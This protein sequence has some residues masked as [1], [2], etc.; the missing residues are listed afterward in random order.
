[1]KRKIKK[2]IENPHRTEALQYTDKMYFDEIKA[3][4]GE[5]SAKY[6]Y[7]E[8]IITTTPEQVSVP[9]KK[10]DFIVKDL[11]FGHIKVYSEEIFNKLYSEVYIPK[12]TID[13][14]ITS[15]KIGAKVSREIWE[16]DEYLWI[17]GI[18]K[19][20]KSSSFA[21][22]SKLFSNPNKEEEPKEILLHKDGKDDIW[23]PTLEDVLAADWEVVEEN[24]F[25]A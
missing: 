20:E 17:K 10:G 18:E 5:H 7:G 23:Q 22:L 8:I 24:D 15:L 16:D 1:M 19:K 9:L 3:F 6:E 11:V 4:V 25:S 12:F 2:C 14:A 21:I 13:S